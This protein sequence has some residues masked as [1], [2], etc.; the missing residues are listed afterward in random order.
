MWWGG[1]LGVARAALSTL[2]RLLARLPLWLGEL[3]SVAA[4][5]VDPVM[6]ES[7]RRPREWL[8]RLWDRTGGR[9]PSEDRS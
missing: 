4:D 9:T 2:L 1:I 7:I 3:L 6:P 8:P 5:I